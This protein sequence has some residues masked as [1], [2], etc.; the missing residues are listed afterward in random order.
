MFKIIKTVKE[1]QEEAESFRLAKKRIGLVPTMGYLHEGH[2][3]LIRNIRKE[4]D[5]LVVSIFINPTQFGPQEDLKEYPRDFE[6]DKQL[7]IDAGG[8]IIFFPTDTEI[9]GTNYLTFVKVKKWGE[10]MCGESRPIHFEGVTTIVAKL[11]NIVKPHRAVFG[12]KDAQQGAIINKM[13]ADLNFD[14]DIKISPTIREKD[15]LAMSSR[16]FYLNKEGRKEAVVLFK[17][18]MTARTAIENGERNT[19]AIKEMI[20]RCFKDYPLAVLEYVDIRDYNTL[21]K[22]DYL[23]G[24]VLIALAAKIGVTRLIDNVIVNLIDEKNPVFT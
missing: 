1:M 22:P 12:Q 24:E 17:S 11:F 5:I 18:L 4:C 7:V 16:N 23:K 2:L 3:S 10:I 8:D 15:G 21:L 20:Y 9:Y 6:E 19:E 14:I 13:A